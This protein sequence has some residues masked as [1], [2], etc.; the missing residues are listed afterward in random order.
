MSRCRARWASLCSVLLFG[1]AIVAAFVSTTRAA[2]IVT[3][4]TNTDDLEVA[5]NASGLSITS[6]SILN[7]VAG[8][9]G[10][11]TDFSIRPV[12]LDDGIVLSSGNVEFLLPPADPSL[13]FP[14]PS[15]DMQVSGTPE[16]DLY[17]PGNIENFESSNDVASLQVN[18]HLDE[19]SQIKFD[20]VFGSVE[21]PFYTSSFTDAFLVFLDGTDAVNQVTFDA[22]GA[23]VQVGVA[24]AGEVITVDANTAFAYPHGVLH[25]LTTTSPM[26]AAGDHFLR[27]E[28]GDVNDHILD[29]AVFIANLRTGSGDDGTDPIV[30]EPATWGLGLTALALLPALRRRFRR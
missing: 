28:V 14:Q 23:P 12:T 21:F 4:T 27:F 30:P 25:E 15:Y 16:F 11:Y 22:T 5:L 29:S 20:F 1:V 3:P 18:F 8:Q 13:D 7:G 26:L 19:D 6:V 10:T 24:F 2:I 9:F 17:G